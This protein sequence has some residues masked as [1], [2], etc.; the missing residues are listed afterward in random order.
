MKTKRILFIDFSTR[1]KSIVDLVT[2]ARGGMVSSLFKVSDALSQIG[3]S[4]HVVSDISKPGIT[5]A[6]VSW[7]TENTFD[8]SIRYDAL[9]AN[10]GAGYAF[11]DIKAKHRVLWT[12]DL[13]HNGFAVEPKTLNLYNRVVFMSRYAERVWRKFFKTI[14][15][16]ALIPNGVDK[17]LFCPR[18]KVL[19]TLVYISAPNRG[20]KRLP[21]IFEALKH[22]SN[23][24][25]WFYAYSNM[26]KLH[27]GEVLNAEDD[28]FSLAYKEVKE[29]EVDLKDPIPQKDLAVK[30]GEAGLMILPTDYPEICSNSILQSLASGTPVITTGNLGSAGEW[31]KHGKNGM[32]TEFHPVDY[33]IHSVEMVRNALEVLNNPAKHRKMMQAAANT[34]NILTWEQVGKKWD[35]M[36]RSL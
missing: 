31:I 20:L 12:H 16:S 32:L 15:K 24:G 5:G 36:I 28:G 34:K 14:G 11:S 17:D 2:G 23:Q 22:R 10:R 4:V 25:L 9:I 1:L 3:H 30:L 27:P 35:K 29:S 26:A 7:L 21:L 8:S 19:G 6:G 13:P 33:M 18:D